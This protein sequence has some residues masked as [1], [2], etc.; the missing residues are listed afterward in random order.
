MKSVHKYTT[1]LKV[2]CLWQNPSVSSKGVNFGSTPYLGVIHIG[3]GVTKVVMLKL[4][5]YFPCGGKRNLVLCI[6]VKRKSTLANK[7][8]NLISIYFEV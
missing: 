8:C 1:L 3:R 5:K 4:K 7:A 6:P 2:Y